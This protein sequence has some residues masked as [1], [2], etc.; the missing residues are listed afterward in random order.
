ME[1]VIDGDLENDDD[2]DQGENKQKIFHQLNYCN[3]KLCSH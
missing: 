2:E 1:L 3:L